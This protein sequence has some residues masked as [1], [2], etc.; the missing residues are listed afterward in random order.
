MQVKYLKNFEKDIAK[1][2]SQSVSDEVFQQIAAIKECKSL[3]DFIRLPNVTK[4]VGHIDCY[5]IKFGD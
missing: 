4:L 5:R 1:I 3:V 2:R